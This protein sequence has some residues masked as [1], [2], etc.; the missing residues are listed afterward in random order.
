MR[1]IALGA[2]VAGAV[3]FLANA[4][5]RNVLRDRVLAFFRR[6]GRKAARSGR[7]V[8]AEAYGV[9]QKLRHRR[10]QPKDYDD[11]TLTRKVETQIFRDADA[12][13]GSVDV[14]VQEGI[15]QLRG[16]VDRPQVID[17]LVRQARGVQG[18]RDVE[19]LLHLPGQPPMHQ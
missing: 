15:V 16:E 4:R 9:T 13:K 2:G 5:R 1:R 3:A 7:G 12:P 11:A 18:V 14:N 6:S 8:K 17:E 10:E 19:N